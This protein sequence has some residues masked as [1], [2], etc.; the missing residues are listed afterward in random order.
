VVQ[1]LDLLQLLLPLD[2]LLQGRRRRAASARADGD[3]TKKNRR[4]DSK[5]ERKS[6]IQSERQSER[7][8]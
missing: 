5:C 4:R 3:V 8:G 2:E 6:E 1:T 7:S